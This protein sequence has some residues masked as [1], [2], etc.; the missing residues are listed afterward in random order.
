MKK[1][2]LTLCLAVFISISA[3]TSNPDIEIP[4]EIAALEE[5]TIGSLN[6][7]PIQADAPKRIAIF[8]DTDDVIIGQLQFFETDHLGRVFI[9]DASLNVIHVY[10]P[11]G[12]Y[13]TKIGGEGDGPGEFRR[14]NSI[15]FDDRYL[16][17][18]DGQSYRIS[19][20]DLD[21]FAYAE[22]LTFPFE[23][24][25]SGGNF[26]YPESFDLI[27]D[28]NYLIHFG[29]G[30]SMGQADDAKERKR[31]GKIFNAT[32]G[33]LQDDIIY[34]FPANE[35]LVRREGT[36]MNVMSMPYNRRSHIQYQ[37]GFIFQGWSEELLFR[38]YDTSGEYSHAMYIPYENA[39]LDRDS[40]IREYSNRDEPWR[41]MVRN[42]QM[43][44]TWPAFIKAL[45]DDENR[46]WTGLYTNDPE[47]Y[48]WK[49]FSQDGKLYASFVW[50]RYKT[51]QSVRNGEIY[52]IETDPDTDLRQVA[53]YRFQ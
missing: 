17:V 18:M 37:D 43:P 12:N 15:T 47:S 19:R 34:S 26:V 33:I 7:D 6:M 30:F 3:C 46:V 21:T 42:D 5:L 10:S 4:E 52:T 35:A 27:H 41:S 49:A 38:W 11:E 32:S 2:Y 29:L 40:I 51:I 36:S 16:H 22:D 25:F 13:L 9:A 50:P 8:G 44:L 23:P 20:F 1:E 48:T 28:G 31:T 14:I 45:T 24:D 39:P 53:K